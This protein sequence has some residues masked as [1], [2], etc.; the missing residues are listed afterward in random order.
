ML[1][2]TRVASRSQEEMDHNDM[3]LKSL[4]SESDQ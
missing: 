2:E 3:D 4:L 1:G